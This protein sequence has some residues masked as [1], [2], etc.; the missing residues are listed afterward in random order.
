MMTAKDALAA[1]LAKLTP[2]RVR[3]SSVEQLTALAGRIREFL[4]DLPPAAAGDVAASLATVELTLAL[5]HAFESPDDKIVWDTGGQGYTH[6]IVT[7]RADR[8]HTLNTYG[9]MS[10][11]LT[12]L[13]S[14]HD[15]VDASQRGTA[16]SVALGLAFAKALHGETQSVVAVV[17]D[18]ALA[19]GVAF[20]A[21]NHAAAATYTNLVVVLNDSGAGVGAL[22]EYLRSLP[23]GRREPEAIFTSLGFDYI[24]PI[25]G[26]D[27]PALTSALAAAKASTQIPLV[28][29]RTERGRGSKPPS[30]RTRPS[31]TA[32]AGYAAV[33]AGVIA[34]VMAGDD[35][36]VV[37]AP[38]AR[39]TAFQSL[40][41]TFPDRAFDPGFEEQ[42]AAALAAGFAIGQC[43]PILVLPEARLQRAF[44][45]VMRDVCF[46]SL[47]VL[48]LALGS[49]FAGRSRPTD[50]GI[51]D[52]AWRSAPNL[53]MMAPKD[54]FEL[55]RMVRDRVAD[56]RAPALIAVPDGAADAVDA[57]VLD[58]TRAAFA[59][60]QTVLDGKDMTIIAVGRAFAVARAVADHLRGTHVGCGLVNL[61]YVQPLPHDPLAAILARAPRAVTL[62]EGVIDNGVGSAI[63]A[64]AMDLRL[65]CEV[66]RLGSPP[67]FLAAGSREE[68][69]ALTGLDRDGVLEKIA[70]RWRLH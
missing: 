14:E 58:E 31:P 1:D 28:H 40:F 54:R 64:L 57:T 42:H 6:K 27:L 56:L 16:I 11:Y 9:G 35:R 7:G 37:I 21:L 68:L 53:R 62:E 17:D 34:E 70:R 10:P 4:L 52:A 50:H 33:A 20:E 29:A 60:P 61:R 69:Y 30:A 47:P 41:G 23:A 32:V 26:H 3:A 38:G 43:T 18:D 49:G 15:V 46:G 44:D 51:H 67:A 39:G 36:V 13:E 65:K 48:I 8:F 24:G 66:L 2:A 63:A 25:D 45:Q 5:H 12:R 59:L 22:H 19:E 55:E